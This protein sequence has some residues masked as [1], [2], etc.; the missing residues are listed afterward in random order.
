MRNSRTPP[1]FALRFLR[2]FCPEDLCEGI[3]GD[4]M[5]AFNQELSEGERKARIKF[6]VRV[7]R[8]FRPGIL[9]RN[10]IKFHFMN[11]L[12]LQNYFKV[13]FRNLLRSKAYSAITIG[14][15]AIGIACSLVIFLF[16]Y[17]EW[18]YDKGFSKADRIYRIGIS[19]FNIGQF[20]N[21]PEEL[22]DVLPKEFDG[23]ETATRVRKERD[24]PIKIKDATFTETSVYYT[25]SAYFKIFNYT[26][27]SGDP[28]Q[29]LIKPNEAVVT[30][31]LAAKLFGRID[32]I[33][34]VVGVGKKNEP[35]IIS[36]VVK[37][38]GFNSHLKTDIWLSNQGFITGE[39]VWSSSAF[40]N[41]VLL[42]EKNSE[43]DL[44]HA[45]DLLFEHH[46]YPESGV[47]MGF[48][49]LED[50]RNNDMSIKFYVHKL[51][52]IYLKSK[53]NF[54]ISP[55]GNESN[56]YIF[57]AV[58]LFILIL[59][60]VNFVNLTTARAAR[61]A[62]EVG[63]RKAMG[64]LRGKLVVQFLL[65]SI[66]TSLLSLIFA[67]LLA[68]VFL[69]VFEMVTGTLLLDT[70]WRNPSSVSLFFL[71]SFIVGVLSGLYPAFYLTSF[72][73]VKVLKGNI[74]TGGTSFRNFL[75]VFQFTV[76]ILLISCAL[77]VQS[78]LHFMATKDLGFDQK[79]I[80][81]IDQIKLLKTSDEAF[82]N[83]LN[84]LPGVVHSSFHMGEPGSKRILTFHA[85]QTAI[86]EHPASIFTYLADENFLALNGMR[87]LKGRD[88]NKDMASDT[89]SVILNESAVQMLE[90]GR[91]PIGA[92]LDQKLRVIGVVSDFH[93]E[94]LRSKIG[95]LAIMLT[96][97]RA[98]LGFKVDAKA[99]PSF[100]KAAEEK[101]KQLV[102]DEPFQYHFVDD[103]FEE[104]LG[105][106][107]V[108]GKAINVFTLLAIF[109]SCL[110]LYGLSAFTAEQRTKEIGIRKVLGATATQIVTM[111]NKK[112]TKLV[113]TA[114]FV[115]IPLSAYL[116]QKWL[117]GFA[118]RIELSPEIFLLTSISSL[119]I[120]WL[121]VSY[122][123]VKAAWINPSE[124]LKY[125]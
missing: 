63:I 52:D 100:L 77:V 43:T 112:F 120:A 113:I 37:E 102:P 79:N 91:K 68:E 119:L 48:K 38:L 16:V 28:N 123:S 93:W 12:L 27:L 70:I 115:S 122:H 95:P 44:R 41:Y 84:N 107:K 30:R 99:I 87:L 23:V 73:P 64:T 33:G 97:E 39:P 1:R 26:F 71:F 53:L 114:L 67:L 90:I 40:Y 101:W 98:E 19:F 69:K 96:K 25:D 22:L 5:E 86:M 110:G 108:F 81:T 78:Q 24:V 32:V 42:K 89:A 7:F 2:W 18:S 8:F 103:N 59:A 66:T 116:I 65:E 106:E 105:K 109:I 75:V 15:L 85:Y 17:G 117:E 76:S 58:S 9:F 55:G 20:A 80:I 83:E 36:G 61:R 21:G 6:V 60:A 11:T 13:A 94:S 47:P 10:R 3:E 57:S 51:T 125:E 56:I 74:E 92:V 29:V 124:S 34:E 46:V 45:L 118:Y 4:V 35:F 49:T 62:K 88:F 82:K 111:L 31:K 14:G 50:Y 54:E 72:I 121:A 104:M